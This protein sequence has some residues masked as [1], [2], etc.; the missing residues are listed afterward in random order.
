M[1]RFH[2]GHGCP[3]Y[4]R[5]PCTLRWGT[6]QSSAQSHPFLIPSHLLII[7]STPLDTQFRDTFPVPEPST[8]DLSHR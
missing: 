1:P 8:P 3:F 5:E 4:L 7:I 6:L 2:R